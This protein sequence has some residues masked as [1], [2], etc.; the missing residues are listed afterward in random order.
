[1][2]SLRLQG[3]HR[4]HQLDLF[5]LGRQ[6]GVV[7]G[8]AGRQRERLLALPAEREQ[9]VVVIQLFAVNF[10]IGLANAVDFQAGV[11]FHADVFHLLS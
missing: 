5:F 7:E 4:R 2:T 3:R 11:D 10:L 8:R 1:M 6:Q 9:G